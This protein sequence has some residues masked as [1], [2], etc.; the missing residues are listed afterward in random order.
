ML[1]EAL[2]DFDGSVLVVSHDR[3]FLDRICDQIIS[4]EEGGLFVQ[5]GNYSY[6]LEKKKEREA[7]NQAAWSDALKAQTTKPETRLRQ[8][9]TGP[10]NAALKS[11]ANWREWRRLFWPR[12]T[13][14][15][16]WR[17]L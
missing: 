13:A 3:Y 14:R 11:S 4:F 10:G 15:T 2:A 5:T 9:K 7:R 1:E 12:K 16:S 8:S 6:Y 17:L